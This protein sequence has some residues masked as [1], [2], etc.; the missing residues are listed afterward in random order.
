MA[1]A[2]KVLTSVKV[3]EVSL[4]LQTAAQFVLCLVSALN[5]CILQCFV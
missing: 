1:N 5:V 4:L 2:V 3:K